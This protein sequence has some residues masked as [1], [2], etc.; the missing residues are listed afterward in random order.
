M[1]KRLVFSFSALTFLFATT[2]SSQPSQGPARGSLPAPQAAEQPRGPQG[3]PIDPAG[4]RGI[5]PFMIKI[6]E[7]NAAYAARDFAASVAAYQEA[8]VQNPEHPLGHYMLGQAQLAAGQPA[9][10]EAAYERGI[11][12]AGEDKGL[13]VKLLFVLANLHERQ[14]R[15]EDAKKAYTTYAAFCRANPDVPG[16]PDN[17]DARIKVI[18]RREELARQAALVKKRAEEREK[19]L[20]LTKQ[21]QPKAE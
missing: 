3:Q 18:E 1:R 8:I 19:E 10:A 11:R 6:L 13:H 17:A 20:G 5:S 21:E 9:D 16:Y 4:Q 12:F 14:G 7:G 15:F 2:G